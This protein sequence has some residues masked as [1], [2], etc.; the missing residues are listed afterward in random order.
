MSA[1]HIFCKQ[2]ESL[3]NTVYI[4]KVKKEERQKELKIEKFRKTKRKKIE[5]SKRQKWKGEIGNTT[6]YLILGPINDPKGLV[7]LKDLVKLKRFK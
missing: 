4:Q 1:S 6:E 2:H 3:Y 5:K 7:S